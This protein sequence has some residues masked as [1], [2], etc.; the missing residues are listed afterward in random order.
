MFSPPFD[1]RLKPSPKNREKVVNLVESN[2]CFLS[3]EGGGGKKLEKGRGRV[4]SR[5]IESMRRGGGRGDVV[6]GVISLS[7]EYL[8]FI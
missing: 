1:L 2:E 4:I 6:N 3:E 5:G 7:L 8:H